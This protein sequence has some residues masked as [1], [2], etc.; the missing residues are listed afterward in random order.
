M[1]LRDET[2]P[3]EPY[4]YHTERESHGEVFYDTTYV[5]GVD[6]VTKDKSVYLK[7][8]HYSIMYKCPLGSQVYSDYII[9]YK[10]SYYTG[11]Y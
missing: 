2:V 1:S 3:R 5:D 4:T 6:K 10:E 11:S 9:T 7:P 8:D